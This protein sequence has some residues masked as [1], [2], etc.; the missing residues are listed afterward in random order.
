MGF[1]DSI[2]HRIEFKGGDVGREEG[3]NVGGEVDWDDEEREDNGEEVTFVEGELET[4]PDLRLE[5]FD[6]E[7]GSWAGGRVWTGGDLVRE[8]FGVVLVG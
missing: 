3:A 4:P 2:R 5:L 6:V 8:D 7:T 1:L